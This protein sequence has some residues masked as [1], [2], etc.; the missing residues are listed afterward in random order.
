[1]FV[2]LLSGCTTINLESSF[3][4]PTSLT[5]AVGKEY[6]IVG[7]F[8]REVRVFFTLNAGVRLTDTNAELDR[9]LSQEVRWHNGDGV[10]NLRVKVEQDPI[11]LLVS[12]AGVFLAPIVL[13]WGAD[14]HSPIPGS[15]VWP[16]TAAALVAPPFLLQTRTLTLEGDVFKYN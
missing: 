9:A 14:A 8:H 6:T 1:M 13:L 5:N 10:V 16:A 11:D 7:R 15:W 12:S 4:Q 3:S 2:V